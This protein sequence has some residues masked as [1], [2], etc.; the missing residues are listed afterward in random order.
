MKKIFL[1]TGLVVALLVMLGAGCSS[2]NQSATNPYSS[3]QNTAPSPTGSNTGTTKVIN[4]TAE[5]FK[6][7]PSTVTV[8]MGDTVE[9]HL[10]S[11]DVAHGFGLPDFNV[12]QTVDPGG[13]TVISFVAN[14]TGTFKF[15]CTIPCGPGHADM[16]GTLVVN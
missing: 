13:S 7:S 4:M 5:K 8:N 6:F 3:G 11:K 10:T 16:T 9:I 1:K 12:N 15:M 14:K 2:A